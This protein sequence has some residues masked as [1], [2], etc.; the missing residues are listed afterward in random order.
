MSDTCRIC[1][2]MSFEGTIKSLYEAARPSFQ[3]LALELQRFIAST[4]D[5]TAIAKAAD[6]AQKSGQIAASITTQ[7]VEE[8][9]FYYVTR[10]AYAALGSGMY[11]EGYRNQNLTAAIGLCR[12]LTAENGLTCPEATD[13][14]LEEAEAAM[15]RH[16]DSDFS[17]VS[18]AGSP[19]P[20][21]DKADGTGEL[22]K[23]NSPV[24]GSGVDMSAD[25][26]SLFAY[27]NVTHYGQDGWSPLYGA[28]GFADPTNPLFTAVVERNPIFRCVFFQTES[29]F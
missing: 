8:F 13:V 23:G 18:T 4:N 28:S 29:D 11:Q 12:Q 2:E 1:I 27:I 24:G 14:T 21:W 9:Y 15:L 26:R 22:F 16:A 10:G 6:L 7:A 3:V 25:I 5:T 19:L 20:F 17:S